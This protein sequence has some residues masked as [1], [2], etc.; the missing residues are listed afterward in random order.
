M[1]SACEG[2]EIVCPEGTLCGRITG[3]SNGHIAD[4]GFAMLEGSVSADGGRYLCACCERA[5]AVREY[6]RWRVHLR[7]GWV[8]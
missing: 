3:E 4:G 1:V 6:L 7:R 8:R 2:E 5:V